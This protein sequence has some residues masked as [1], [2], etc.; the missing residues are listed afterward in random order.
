MT[1]FMTF[2]FAVLK[3]HIFI[4]IGQ[5]YQFLIFSI[6]CELLLENIFVPPGITEIHIGIHLFST[7]TFVISFCVCV[8]MFRLL[9]NVELI[10]VWNKA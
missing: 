3:F 8:C 2:S 6:D 5:I 9:N 10:L 7:G 1:L 4:F